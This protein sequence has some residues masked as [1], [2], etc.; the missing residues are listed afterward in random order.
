MRVKKECSISSTFFGLCIDKL[1]EVITMVARE[2]GLDTRKFM[3]QYILFLLY[4][5]EIILFSYNVDGMQCLL[6]S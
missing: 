5:D 2:E 6:R 3:E 4:V 1:E